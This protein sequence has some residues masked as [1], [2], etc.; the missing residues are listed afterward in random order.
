MTAFL[1]L[2]AGLALVWYL[3]QR[4]RPRRT[5]DAYSGADGYVDDS[6]YSGTSSEPFSGGGGAFGGGGASGDWNG[7]DSSGGSDGGGGD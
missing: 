4:R 2:V 1:L 5:R 6:E 3:L 7:P